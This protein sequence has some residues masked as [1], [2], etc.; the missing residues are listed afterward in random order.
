MAV[1]AK[2]ACAA[3]CLRLRDGRAPTLTNDDF[4]EWVRWGLLSRRYQAL[5]L[6]AGPRGHR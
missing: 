1:R 4:D 2:I 6:R 3:A 5:A